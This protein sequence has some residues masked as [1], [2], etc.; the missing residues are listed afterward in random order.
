VNLEGLAS[1]I[2]MGM[3]RARNNQRKIL[4]AELIQEVIDPTTLMRVKALGMADN[5]RSLPVL[6]QA[7]IS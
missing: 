6:C 7:V 4:A 1:S 3:M 2:M 5:I